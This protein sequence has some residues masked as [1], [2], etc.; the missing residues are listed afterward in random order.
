MRLRPMRYMV[1]RSR[2]ETFL[3]LPPL[4]IF[5][6]QTTAA[7]IPIKT[8]PLSHSFQDYHINYMLY[9][10]ISLSLTAPETPPAIA[11]VFPF[12]FS[13]TISTCFAALGTFIRLK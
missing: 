6:E 7:M 9:K 11:A 1:V 13:T 4:P 10:I 8:T 5:P 2:N 3:S 12:F